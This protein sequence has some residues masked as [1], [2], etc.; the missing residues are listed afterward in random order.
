MSDKILVTD[1]NYK[2]TLGIIRSLGSRSLNISCGST[3]SIHIPISSYSKYVK[4]TFFYPDPKNNPVKFCEYIKKI[5]NENNIRFLL[6]VGYDAY[7]AI[8]KNIQIFNND[9]LPLPEL[10]SFEIAASKSATVSLAN[11]LNI[12]APISI[13]LNKI[14]DLQ[15]IKLSYPLV[16]KGIFSSGF[17]KYANNY[18]ELEYWVKEITKLQKELPL[19]QEY[20]SGEG[21]GFFGLFN[22]GSPRAFFMHK[23]IREYPVSG[24]PST[25][26]KS[27]F[28]K[29]ILDY[30]L[31]IMKKLKW[32]GVGMV[33]FKKD[34]KD[35]NFK[36]MEIN[37]KFWG[38]LDLAIASGVDFPY[39]LYKMLLN[40]D[41]KP[42]YNYKI[43]L[44]YMWPFPDDFNRVIWNPL[45]FKDFSMDLINPTVTKN[46]ETEDLVPNIM[47]LNLTMYN[48]IKKLRRR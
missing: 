4:S 46:I 45:N 13:K 8:A 48:L 11:E 26:A 28:D 41:I 27:I 43:G 19:I 25:C 7:S 32:H 36:I 16:V 38:S 21:Y 37:P 44:K 40:G 35:G 10:G 42:V 18:Q 1:A 24:G 17:V 2:H 23:R 22:K 15:E 12:P 29:R 30:G 31:T 9:S 39:L 33:E 5:M 14:S 20:I 34:I 3:Y 47:Q 6:P